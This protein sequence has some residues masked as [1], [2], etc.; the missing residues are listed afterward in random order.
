[1]M[2]CCT[3]VE[4][5]Q[6]QFDKHSKE[7]S[8]GVGDS[9]WV[10]IPTAGKL[11]PRLEGNWTIKAIKSPSPLK[12]LMQTNVRWCISIGYVNVQS[13]HHRIDSTKHMEICGCRHIIVDDAPRYPVDTWRRPN[14]LGISALIGGGGGAYVI[15]L[16]TVP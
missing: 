16:Y 8:F 11:D 13:Y 7:R 4:A 5:A 2:H 3:L 6:W 14:W 9:V 15:V 10:S 1:M 12:F